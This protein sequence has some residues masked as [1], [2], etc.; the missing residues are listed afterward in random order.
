[1]FTL[2]WGLRHCQSTWGG[3]DYTYWVSRKLCLL[4]RNLMPDCV[5]QDAAGQDGKETAAA[6]ADQQSLLTC[7]FWVFPKESLSPSLPFSPLFSGPHLSQLTGRKSDI[8]NF[9][10]TQPPYKNRKLQVIYSSSHKEGKK[11]SA[12]LS[13]ILSESELPRKIVSP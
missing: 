1:M 11:L 4:Q 8:Q 9:F 2:C 10:W 7:E 5:V 13:F 3:K 6:A 12:I